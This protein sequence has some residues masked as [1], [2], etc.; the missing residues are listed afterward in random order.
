M[1]KIIQN[2]ILYSFA[3]LF[4]QL[5]LAQKKQ[6]KMRTEEVNVV[7]SYTPT[8]SDAFKIKETPSLN[9]E[10]TSAKETVKYSIFSFPVASTFT[11]S[12]GSAEDVD[13]EQIGRFYKSYATFGGGNYGTLNAELFATQDLNTEEYVAGMFRH[14]SSQGGIKGT[15]LKD[16]F[17][18]TSL[19]LTYGAEAKE[20]SWNINL[21]YQNQ[22]YHWYGLPTT[23]MNWL[24]PSTHDILVAGID[25]KQFYNTITLDSKIEF[26]ESILEASSFKFAHFS[27]AFGSSENRFY[28]K[29]SFK[30]AAFGKEIKL[31]AIV[32]YLG[33]KFDHNFTRTNV[34]PIEY[35][36]TNFGLSPSYELEKDNWTM[37]LGLGLYYSLDTKNSNNQLFLYPQVTASHKI[38]GD[39]MIFY[40]GAEGGLDQN[41]YLNFVDE[42][43]FLSPTLLIAPTNK[44]YDVY[45]GLKGKLADNISYNVRGSLVDENNK[46]LFRSND[47][48]A[49]FN[50][51]PYSYGNSL[52]LVYDNVKTFRLFGELKADITEAISFSA[53]GTL[54]AYTTKTQAE[55]WNLP[56]IKLNA[57]LDY[58]INPKWYA[59]ADVFFVGSRKDSQINNDLMT[60][61]AQTYIPTT[62]K[63]YIDLN[64]H[65]GYKHSERLTAFLKANNI[66]NQSYQ[67]WMNYPV[68]GFQ[69]VLGANYK[70]DF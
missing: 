49:N 16:S 50:Y 54:S 3:L 42:N 53:N 9:E 70:F 65:V 8:I 57:T 30:F 38:V 13:K 6:E 14:L 31:N 35:G 34:E 12:K 28:A 33:G 62:L 2:S 61:V 40:T 23:F 46:A 15:E 20:L 18:D 69:V 44:K 19:D 48:S 39:L 66:L 25:P 27:D 26:N 11:P 64:A 22:I 52:Q 7:K 21:G 45:A 55:A 1:R 63:S 10:G 36:Y 32:D 56:A 24:L 67:K 47:F 43:P 17:Y 58:T 4:V 29:P 51:G 37:H 41:S 60:I 68:Q 59:G 5:G